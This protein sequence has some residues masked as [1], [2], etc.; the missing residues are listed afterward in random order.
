MAALFGKI[1][2]MGIRLGSRAGTDV[3]GCPNIAERAVRTC[4]DILPFPRVFD[5]GST[6][7]PWGLAPTAAL[8][9]WLGIRCGAYHA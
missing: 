6:P 4:P 2:P 5:A 9:S 8:R 7:E 3:K 1:P